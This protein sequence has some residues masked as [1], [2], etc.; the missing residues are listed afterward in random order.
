MKQNTVSMLHHIG[1]F[2]DYVMDISQKQFCMKKYPRLSMPVR[3][4]SCL[5]FFHLELCSAYIVLQ[6]LSL[7]IVVD[8][9][10]TVRL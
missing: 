9:P 1:F 7:N 2:A 6:T 8:L 5:L 10:W 3:A 4:E